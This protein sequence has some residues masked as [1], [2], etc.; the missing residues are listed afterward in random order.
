MVALAL[1]GGA[2]SACGDDDSDDAPVDLGADGSV[3]VTVVEGTDPAFAEEAL[4]APAGSVSL[5]LD[6]PA[7]Q[8]HDLVIED[9]DGNEIGRTQPVAA[10][11]TAVTVTLAPGEYTFFCSIDGHREAGM[12]GTLTA[13]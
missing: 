2:L 9:A 4:T 12:E 10:G 8:R 7:D 3:N 11:T 13:E 1:A 5:L 6:N